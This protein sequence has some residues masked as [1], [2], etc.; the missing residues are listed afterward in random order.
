MRT[1]N[2]YDFY[3]GLSKGVEKRTKVK[4]RIVAQALSELIASSKNVILM[5]PR[6]AD[7]DCFGALARLG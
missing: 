1:K 2:G 3:G 7:M 5:G 4:T 6:F